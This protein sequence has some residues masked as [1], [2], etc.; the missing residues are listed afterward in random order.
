MKRSIMLAKFEH[1][2]NQM[3]PVN[4]ISKAYVLLFYKHYFDSIF[5]TKSI[6]CGK[7]MTFCTY[8]LTYVW[9]EVWVNIYVLVQ[10]HH[11]SHYEF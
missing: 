6:A 8:F 2:Q 3:T 5:A 7:K 4:A 1:K 9:F 10:I 11:G